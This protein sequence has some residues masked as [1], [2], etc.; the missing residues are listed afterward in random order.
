[1]WLAIWREKADLGRK[2]KKSLLKRENTVNRT[3]DQSKGESM[4]RKQVISHQK[5]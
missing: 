4:H 2:V 5:A 3:V 1:M